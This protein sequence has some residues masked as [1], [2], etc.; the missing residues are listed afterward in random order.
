MPKIPFIS[1]A[2]YFG[3]NWAHYFVNKTA[4]VINSNPTSEGEMYLPKHWWGHA[5]RMLILSLLIFVGKRLTSSSRSIICHMM[6]QNSHCTD[7]TM[8]PMHPDFCY[9]CLPPPQYKKIGVREEDCCSSFADFFL[10]SLT[11]V[12]LW[13]SMSSSHV[14]EFTEMKTP[15]VI[16]SN[17]LQLQISF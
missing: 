9:A 2:W 13:A 1:S 15:S 16:Y 12:Y 17:R 10:P 11:V 3:S 6:K 5:G 7:Q 8:S 14:M 4:D